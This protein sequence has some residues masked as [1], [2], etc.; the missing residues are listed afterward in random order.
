MNLK[1]QVWKYLPLVGWFLKWKGALHSKI[2][3]LNKMSCM[4]MCL[5][6]MPHGNASCLNELP[7]FDETQVMAEQVN[8]MTYTYIF[9]FISYTT[10]LFDYDEWNTIF[11]FLKYCY[12]TRLQ[13]CLQ[14]L[15]QS[16]CVE[17][18]RGHKLFKL[19][20]IQTR[21]NQQK[22]HL[23]CNFHMLVQQHTST[24]NIIPNV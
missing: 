19:L 22:L 4:T 8:L 10:N 13:S 1:N 3:H 9:K 23:P 11:W 15:N 14:I 17:K 16:V 5:N 20:L 6:K 2:C 7:E 24:S 18:K 12:G 21:S